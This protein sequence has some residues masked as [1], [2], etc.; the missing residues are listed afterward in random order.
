MTQSRALMGILTR[1][2]RA[3]GAGSL[4]AF[5]LALPCPT[6]AQT[7]D[8]AFDEMESLIFEDQPLVEPLSHPDWFKLSFLDLD[9]DLREVVA[10]GKRGLMIYFGQ[11]DCAY[12]KA[13][14]ETNFG[15]PD[16]ETYTRRHFDVIGIDIHGD[17][18][19]TDFD[20]AEGSERWYAARLGV[21]FTPTL[22]FYDTTGKLVLRLPGYYPPYQFRAALE[23]VADGHHRSESFRTYLARADVPL[24]FEEGSLN[25]AEFFLPPPY[26]LAR[27]HHPGER[28]LIVFFEQ[29]DC[30]ACDILHT[31]PLLEPQIRARLGQFETV[32]L[33]LWGK[34]PVLTPDGKRTTEGGW[35]EQLGLFYAPTLLFFDHHGKEVLRVD[36]V[37]QFYRLRNV[38]DYAASG[39]YREY[40]SFQDWR[41]AQGEMGR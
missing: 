32:Q 29:P 10:A 31:G 16:I 34:T 39:A 33:N 18:S 5:A 6:V 1:G 15:K 30:H 11:K 37:V 9:E 21:N 22:M 36:S 26:A 28:P 14:L 40:P 23:Y 2:F 8:A 20:G 19:V 12:C 7:G 4:L 3:L 27:S 38:L 24:A 25:F 17:R 41:K 35:A 13:L